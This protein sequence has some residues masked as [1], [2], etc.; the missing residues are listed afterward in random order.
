MLVIGITMFAYNLPRFRE[1][2]RQMASQNKSS[3]SN[4]QARIAVERKMN[5]VHLNQ[6]NNTADFRE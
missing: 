5:A 4:Q 2:V 6:N 3:A 1:L